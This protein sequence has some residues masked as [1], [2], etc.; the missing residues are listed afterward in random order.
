MKKNQIETGGKY[1]AKVSGK[2]VTVRV[3]SIED[4]WGTL[5]DR[6]VTRYNI[7]N[8]D[9]GRKTIFK[10]AQRFRRIARPVGPLP[11]IE[12]RRTK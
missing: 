1:V 4:K 5:R 9:T 8:L 12:E 6:S 2:I 7:T 10:S 11:T 3:D